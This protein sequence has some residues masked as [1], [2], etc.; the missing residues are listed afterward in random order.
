MVSENRGTSSWDRVR[1]E[2]IFL[3]SSM[4]KSDWIGLSSVRC[5]RRSS[6]PSTTGFQTICEKSHAIPALGMTHPPS[7]VAVM[8][9]PAQP[10]HSG[11]FPERALF[12]QE[13]SQVIWQQYGSRL[14]IASQQSISLQP[15]EPFDS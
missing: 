15:T 1:C 2:N 13:L 14:Q 8:P 11:K 6:P 3:S 12:L 7:I 9:E 10:S 4:I 5:G